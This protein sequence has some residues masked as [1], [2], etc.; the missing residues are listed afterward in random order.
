MS[1]DVA[2]GHGGD[3]GDDY[4]PPTH[5]ISTSCGGCF[6]NRGKGTRKP[7][8]GGRKA[9]RLHTRQETRNLGLKKITDDKGP[10][11]I[12]FEWDDKK[13]LM[14]LG[15]H[16]S[17]WSNYL[18]ELIREMP[19]YYPSW[20]KTQFNLKPHMQFQ[21]WTYINAGIQQHLQKLYNTNKASLKAVHWVINPETGTYDEP[22]P[23]R[24]KSPKPGK[25][26]GH[27][28][29]GIPV[30]YSPSRSDVESS[31]TREYLSLIH[32]FF[33]THTVNEVFTRDEG[34]A[35]YEEMLRLQALGSNTPS[36]V[37]YTEEEINALARKGKQRGGSGGCE[38]DEMANDEDDGE[39][40]EDEEDGDIARESIP[41]ELSPSIYPERHVA[42]DW[43]PQRQVAREGVDLSLGT[44]G[45][46]AR[47]LCGTLWHTRLGHPADQVLNMFHKVLQMSKGSHVS[48]CD[49]CHRAKQTREPFPLSE[50]KTSTV[51]DLIHLDLWGPY[52]VT[53]REG[54]RYF[55]TVVNFSR[56][57]WLYLLKTKDEVCNMFK[58]FHSL[59]LTQF[60]CKIKNVRSDNGIEFVNNNMDMFF[61]HNGIIHQT[62]CPYTPQQNGIAE[63][64]HRH[65]LNAT[66]ISSQ[67]PYDE[68]RATSNDKGSAP[69]SPNTPISVSDGGTATSMGDKS[70]SEGNSQNTQSVLFFQ[71]PTDAGLNVPITDVS[72]EN[73]DEVQPV[74]AT[75]KSTRP[76]KLPAK[77]N[78]Y[79]VNSSKKYGLEKVVNYSKL[80]SGNYCFSTSLNK[81][82]EPSTFYEAIKDRNWID[83]MNAEIEA[84]NRNNTWTITTLPKGRKAI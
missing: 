41:G 26:H 73:T 24:L 11:P 79:V 40:E 72:F 25:E 7:N 10:V 82:I 77:F 58:S 81:S 46:F 9:G 52:K 17:H 30:T 32:T 48:L 64:K 6:A 74:V 56:G 39:D 3:G 35:I 33:V 14:P 59:L 80:S 51:G 12:W 21:R 57:V 38:D 2:R 29:A 31:A 44:V 45:C 63:R 84:L 18:G 47:V 49:T 23:S 69:N 50:H 5:H 61:N 19:L 42:Q 16:A 71:D 36:G 8:F 76:T 75:R 27:M 22:S 78:D 15:D 4:R 67:C 28:P 83:A 20:Q 55:L 66:L 43:F 68:E 70:I 37:P 53:S 65:L 62:T 34:R 13:T 54:F 60:K 1:A